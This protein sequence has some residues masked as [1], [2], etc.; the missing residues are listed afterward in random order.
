M[1]V[2]VA[3]MWE[4]RVPN[5][6]PVP[7]GQHRLTLVPGTLVKGS[8]K[9]RLFPQS[10]R[11]AS[12]FIQEAQRLKFLF[13]SQG[14]SG[15]HAISPLTSFLSFCP[16]SLHPSFP[17]PSLP[18]PL[19]GTAGLTLPVPPCHFLSYVIPGHC[20]QVGGPIGRSLLWGYEQC[21]F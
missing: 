12:P 1:G 15:Y 10:L 5:T 11:T 14:D 19:R 18:P 4:P 3:S 9:D 8:A 16:S 6:F 21:S 2:G 17:L 7:E 20:L 13:L